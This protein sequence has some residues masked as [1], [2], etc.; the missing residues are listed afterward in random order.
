MK[1]LIYLFAVLIPIWLGGC[2]LLEE[3]NKSLGY[4]NEAT[5]YLN[6]LNSFAADAPQL[7]QDAAVNAESKEE[8][9]NQITSLLEEIKNF[10]AIEPPAIAEDIHKELVTKNEVLIE[11]INQLMVNGEILLEQIE[12]TQIYTTIDEMTKFK[13]QLE[14][15]GV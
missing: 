15:L 10:N 9:E 3:A 5:G 7:I 2:S 12:N 13:N 11:Q 6:D 8:L 14:D 4:I 1:K